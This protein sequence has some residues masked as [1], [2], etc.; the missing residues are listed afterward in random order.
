MKFNI[1]IYVKRDGTEPVNVFLYLLE[2][3]L[4]AKVL[5]EIGLLEEFGN[6]LREPHTKLLLDNIFELRVKQARNI[7]R[8]LYFFMQDRKI[9]LTHGFIKKTKKTP[10][11]EIERAKKYRSD[12]IARMEVHSEKI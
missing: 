3:K 10:P 1:E 4:R 6:E 5:R 7:V 12:Y 9:I 8:V 11:K 2:G